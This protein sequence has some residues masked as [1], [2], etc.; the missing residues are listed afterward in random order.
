[1]AA[2]LL[3]MAWLDALDANAQAKPPDG[4]FA[5]VEQSV[6]GSVAPAQPLAIGLG[7]CA[8]RVHQ[9]RSCEHQPGPHPD[10]GQ[11]C[12]RPRTAM[13]VTPQQMRRVMTRALAPHAFDGTRIGTRKLLASR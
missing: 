8:G 9:R 4:E 6:R 12:L 1:M 7:Q 3:R 5:Q 2:I 11:V 13:M 10:H